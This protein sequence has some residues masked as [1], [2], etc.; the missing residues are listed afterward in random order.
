MNCNWQHQ[1]IKNIPY[2]GDYS[3]GYRENGMDIK[4]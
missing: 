4:F 1:E 3:P 2:L